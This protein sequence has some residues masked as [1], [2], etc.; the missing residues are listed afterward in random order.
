MADNN[1]YVRD[2]GCK[3]A[4]CV[5][6]GRIYDS[7]ADKDCI[8]DLRVYFTE[9]DQE[10]VDHATGIRVKKAEVI[11]TYIDVE[12]LPFN[13][14]YYSCDLTV[15]FEVQVEV[16][17]GHGA[18]NCS[19][20][21]TLTGIGVF[22]K[23]VI[24]YGSE[25]NVKVFSSEYREDGCDRQDLPSKNMPRCVVQLAEP[26]I[27]NARLADAG[28]ACDNCCCCGSIPESMCCRYGG[29]FVDEGVQ[30]VVYVSLG[31]FTIVQLIRNTQM[32]IPVYDF[33][34]PSKECCTT[35]DDPCDLF[36]KMGFPVN[37]FFPPADSGKSGC[38]GKV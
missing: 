12:P 1:R 32:L 37:E 21:N 13:R 5:D 22:Q 8:T 34:M 2:N 18:A 10:I 3:E 24:L 27:L 19:P 15:L 14:G 11:T 31:L 33:C 17:S 29:S 28:N 4:V 26:V 20:C 23:K 35:A 30:K 36:K 38:C 6:A 7:C 16:F 25:G 9:R